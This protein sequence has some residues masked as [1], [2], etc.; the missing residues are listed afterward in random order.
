M[1]QRLQTHCDTQFF[2][3]YLF[4]FLTLCVFRA[5]SAHHQERQIVSI[6]SLVSVTP[7]RWPCRV[8]IRKD[9]HTSRPP[10][11]TRSCTNTI[12]LSW[13]WARCAR[14][15]YRVTHKNKHIEK[16][17]A[18][19]WSFI[20]NHY[21]THGQ[22]NIKKK[23]SLYSVFICTLWRKVA[24][25]HRYI[26]S[27]NIITFPISLNTMYIQLSELWLLA[28]FYGLHMRYSLSCIAGQGKFRDWTPYKSQIFCV[29][30]LFN[31]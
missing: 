25:V 10:T 29:I 20:K 23:D 3:M 17:C 1:N 26:A 18:S 21:T 6:Q 16:N 19:R 11:A 13:W 2:S 24:I 15:M 27:L 22:Q 7:C 30:S 12:C 5:H 9:L 4:L 8:R 14:N 31:N 28:F